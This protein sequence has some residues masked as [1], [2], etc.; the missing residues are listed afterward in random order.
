MCLR[1]AQD[2]NCGICGPKLVYFHSLDRVQAWGG[3]RYSAF[4]GRARHLGAGCLVSDEPDIRIVENY[5][6]YV[7]GAAMMVSKRFLMEVGLMAESYFLYYEE[8]DWATRGR[9]KGYRFGYVPD[10]VILH[11][12]GASI[13]SSRDK[14]K[15]SILSEHYLLSS[16]MKFTRRFYPWF[17]PSVFC[18]SLFQI[19]RVA[20]RGDFLRCRVM[21]RAIVGLPYAI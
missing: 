13:G 14:K 5:I 4:F 11:K 16:R 10:A 12:E 6:N 20:M 17:L 9:K 19:V 7:C 18:F 15:R 21:L 3:A 8:I 2:V 1:L